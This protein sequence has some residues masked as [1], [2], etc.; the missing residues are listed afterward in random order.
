M[1][2]E[3]GESLFVKIITEISPNLEGE[4]ERE[5]EREMVIQVQE[6]F[7]TPNRLDQKRISACHIIIK[8]LS[9]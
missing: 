9:I 1:G 4:R 6:V 7:R 8:A 3:V 2:I 5:R